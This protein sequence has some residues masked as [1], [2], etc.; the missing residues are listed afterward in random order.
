MVRTDVHAA[1]LQVLRH[2]F[3]A[4]MLETDVRTL[5]RLPKAK[6]ELSPSSLELTGD[7][8]PGCDPCI[9]EGSG[10]IEIRITES[11]LQGMDLLVAGFPCVDV[12][13]A[14]K[15]AGLAGKVGQSGF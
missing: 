13:R 10:Y 7:W 11:A 9:G 5:E 2:R 1:S 12:S 15:R 3:P 6:S 4:A 14:G 8:Q